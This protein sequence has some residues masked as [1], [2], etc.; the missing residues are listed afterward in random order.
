MIWQCLTAAEIIFFFILPKRNALI[1][2]EIQ[3]NWCYEDITLNWIDFRI[4]MSI[5][6]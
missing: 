4:L 6:Y 2:L 1:L 5:N 3:I